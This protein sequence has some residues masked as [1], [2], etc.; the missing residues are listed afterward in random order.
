MNGHISFNR[1]TP[2]GYFLFLAFIFGLLFA[3]MDYRTNGHGF[4]LSLIFWQIQTQITV[5]FFVLSHHLMVGRL[6]Q[7]TN[8]KKLVAS[9]FITSCLFTP[10][11]L[12]ID[13]V[14]QGEQ[15]SLAALFEEWR[16]MA[17]PA[18]L[19]WV[20]I[21]LPWTLGVFTKDEKLPDTKL[22]KE[23]SKLAEQASID[24]PKSS[25]ESEKTPHF[26]CLCQLSSIDDLLFLKAEL[27]YLKVVTKDSE[28]L[29][30]YNLKDAIAELSALD[31]QYAL[32]QT[33][34]SFWVNKNQAIRFKR[35]GREGQLF[36]SDCQIVNALVSRQHV[37]KVKSWQ[38]Q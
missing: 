18:I 38:L 25:L 29:I 37:P 22:N 20:L 16:N 10:F 7:I 19:C 24:A 1:I 30:L 12:L 28:H 27:H 13:I 6:G 23:E 14:L 31:E 35:S 9:A 21:N 5:A 33:H 34:R 26:F 15:F 2:T 8:L 36:F 4:I 11:S 17:P 3:L 32:W